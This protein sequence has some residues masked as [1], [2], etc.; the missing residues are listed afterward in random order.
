MSAIPG[1]NQIQFEGF[2]RF[3][4][5]GLAEELSKFPKIEDTNQEID[6]EFFLER[7][8]LVEPLIKERDVVY[9]SLAYSSELY[10]S[11]RLIWKNDRRRY[12]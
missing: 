11:A 2:C 9:E 5:Q 3:I 7:Y 10:V 6:F 4:D 12:I 1:F 8:Q